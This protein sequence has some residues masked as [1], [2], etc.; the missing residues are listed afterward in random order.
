MEV[1]LGLRQGLEELLHLVL[2]HLPELIFHCKES[3]ITHLGLV[4]QDVPVVPQATSQGSLIW[5]DGDLV[6][7]QRC[8]TMFNLTV[9]HL[10]VHRLCSHVLDHAEDKLE[11]VNTFNGLPDLLLELLHPSIQLEQA[12]LDDLTQLLPFP[13]D[14]NTS[15]LLD[16]RQQRVA[17][18]A[19]KINVLFLWVVV[20]TPDQLRVLLETLII[21]QPSQILRCQL[22]NEHLLVQ[23]P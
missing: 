2:G 5:C 17:I 12:L 7:A 23:P 13:S 9:L 20:D 8:I 6:L 15:L 14:P 16:L 22:L 21:L 10:N 11:V 4:Q 18:H 3:F 19:N 1:C